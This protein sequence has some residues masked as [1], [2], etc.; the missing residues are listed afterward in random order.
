MMTEEGST[1]IVNFMAPGVRV[2]MLRCGHKRDV[3]KIH[4]FFKIFV[5]IPM[6]SQLMQTEGND[7]PGRVHLGQ[8]FL[9]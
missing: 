8:V 9:C 3:V 1:K 5:F 4:Y 7:V 2:L 6:Q